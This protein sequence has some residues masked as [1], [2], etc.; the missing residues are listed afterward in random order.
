MNAKQLLVDFDRM[1]PGDSMT[2]F[3]GLPFDLSRDCILES[4]D[5]KSRKFTIALRNQAYELYARRKASLVQKQ[6]DTGV[7]DWVIQKR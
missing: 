6:L 1:E 3:T 5:K 7:V 4:E 2:Y